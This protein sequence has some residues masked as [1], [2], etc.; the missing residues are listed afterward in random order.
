MLPHLSGEPVV[1]LVLSSPYPCVSERQWG[2][3]VSLVCLDLP[4]RALRLAPW[5]N[6]NYLHVVVVIIVS[7][8]CFNELTWI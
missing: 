4:I 1:V 5:W 6:I 8:D 2:M 7:F 3:V